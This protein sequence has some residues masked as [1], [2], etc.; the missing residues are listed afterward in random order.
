[1]LSLMK[2]DDKTAFDFCLRFH[3]HYIN[4]KIVNV[5]TQKMLQDNFIS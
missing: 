2:I 5:D 3:K 4:Y 1:M